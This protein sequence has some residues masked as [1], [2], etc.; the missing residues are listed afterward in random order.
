MSL[1]DLV[2]QIINHSWVTSSGE[3]QY[4]YAISGVLCIVLPVLFVDMFYRLFRSI[5]RKGDF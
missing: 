4:I 3:Q 5:F 2:S 1:Y